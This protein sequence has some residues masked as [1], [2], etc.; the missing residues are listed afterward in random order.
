[1][2]R[3]LI[4]KLHTLLEPHL[5]DTPHMSSILI[6]F[7]DYVAHHSTLLQQKQV[8]QRSNDSI[9]RARQSVSTAIMIAIYL[10][11]VKQA[12]EIPI[13]INPKFRYFQGCLDGSYM[14]I[15]CPSEERETWISRNGITSTNAILNNNIPKY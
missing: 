15:I 6:L 11:Y 7:L 10:K 14:P 13:I 1:M 12:T 4:L 2:S 5:H 9:I 8:Y 3:N